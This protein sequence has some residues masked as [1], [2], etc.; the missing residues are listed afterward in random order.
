LEKKTSKKV[1]KWDE[2]YPIKINFSLNNWKIQLFSHHT[3]LNPLL[4]YGSWI[5]N[6]MCNRCLSPLKLW[7]RIQLMARCTH[8][9]F[10]QVCQWL[11][12]GQWFP[13]NKTDHHDIS[14][15][16]LKGVLNTGVL[17]VFNKMNCELMIPPLLG[18]QEVGIWQVKKRFPRYG[19]PISY[20]A[21]DQISDFCHQ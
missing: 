16:L 15:I 12:A 8:Y 2:F 9:N 10:D 18:K 5:Y 3:I 20:E 21:C 4:W 7:V 19:V 14:E 1:L 6:Y 13:Y 11:A 17:T